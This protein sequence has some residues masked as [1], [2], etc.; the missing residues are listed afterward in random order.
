MG[1]NRVG[2]DRT[3][4]N[5]VTVVFPCDLPIWDSLKYTYQRLKHVNN[6]NELLTVLHKIYTL[7]TSCAHKCLTPTEVDNLTCQGRQHPFAGL[8]EFLI[9]V[10]SQ[11]EQHVFFT[12][13]LPFIAVLAEEIENRVPVEGLQ[14]SVRQK[15][16]H[17]SLDRKLIA[18]ILASAFLC[19]FPEKERKGR[20]L[21]KI[22]FTS[23]FVHIQSAPRRSSQSAKLRCILHYFTRLSE[24]SADSPY[25]YVSFIREVKKKETLPCLSDW[26]NCGTVMCSLSIHKNGVIEDSGCHTLQV[27]FANIQI[28][29][30]TLGHGRVQEEIRFCICPEL[31]ASM[32]FM[33]QM[34]ENE[35]IMMSGFEQFSQYSGYAS[36]LQ[37]AGDYRDNAKWENGRLETMI[38]SIDAVSYK[39]K[40]QAQYKDVNILRDLNKAL[41]GFT[42]PESFKTKSVIGQ[43]LEDG[44]EF[45]SC[46]QSA[47]SVDSDF[48]TAP[49]SL[50]EDDTVSVVSFSNSLSKAI[51]DVGIKDAVQLFRTE[52][53][54]WQGGSN[55][56]NEDDD[57]SDLDSDRG[58][59]EQFRRS[60]SDQVQRYG[61]RKGSSE[62]SSELEEYMENRGRLGS[63][64][65]ELRYIRCSIT[66]DDIP[67]A[68]IHIKEFAGNIA[69]QVTKAGYQQ[70]ASMTPGIQKFDAPEPLHVLTKPI[71]RKIT[72]ERQTKKIVEESEQQLDQTEE[73]D[74]IIVEYVNKLYEN[75]FQDAV[76]TDDI[77][78]A[79]ID[80]YA[81][82]EAKSILTNTLRELYVKSELD[83]SSELKVDKGVSEN[84][85]VTVPTVNSNT[86]PGDNATLLYYQ[87]LNAAHSI[88]DSMIQRVFQELSSEFKVFRKS[89]LSL[90]LEQPMQMMNSVTSTP[91]TPPPTPA[92]P[93]HVI[94]FNDDDDNDASYR[95]FSNEL[96]H[97]LEVL[98]TESKHRQ[99]HASRVSNFANNMAEG[100]VSEAIL[101]IHGRVN[102]SV[103]RRGSYHVSTR[104]SSKRSS[105]DSVIED[106]LKIG[107]IDLQGKRRSQTEENIAGFAEELANSMTS[108]GNEFPTNRKGSVTFKDSVLATFSEE[109]NKSTAVSQ[110]KRSSMSKRGS[111]SESITE[112]VSSVSSKITNIPSLANNLANEVISDTFVSL[113]GMPWTCR[114]IDNGTVTGNDDVTMVTENPPL[115]VQFADDM[116]KKLM[117]TVLGV[118][119]DLS[120]GDAVKYHDN[121][122]DDEDEVRQEKKVAAM[123]DTLT[124]DRL[125]GEWIDGI[126][127]CALVDIKNNTSVLQNGSCE[128]IPC[129]HDITSIKEDGIRLA[130]NDDMVGYPDLNGRR[131]IATGNWGCGAF[132]GD[133]QLKSLLQW[134][135]ASVASAPMVLYYTFNDERLHKFDEVS[136]HIR[137]R[138]WNV[139]QLASIILNF[140]LRKQR[141]ESCVGDLFDYILQL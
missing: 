15:G 109:L 39:R 101:K 60:S 64:E 6:I 17:A 4:D 85:D 10:A 115:A 110:N 20:N 95:R 21:N 76:A 61:S 99:F 121:D 45:F 106:L 9:D 41:V 112:S 11:E 132:G 135:A 89:S 94:K 140:S 87:E 90:S 100:I 47:S 137:S 86:M 56:N 74:P 33:E 37:F 97:S 77:K 141:D 68:L 124:L 14:Y 46:V 52:S 111:I 114:D 51:I 125:V 79:N 136:N 103:A 82:V 119:S 128:V 54:G 118:Q 122:E 28:G 18:S 1:K 42:L 70:A 24:S 55:N 123:E 25:G 71:A 67:A 31:I 117:I 107:D 22:N 32:L 104:S 5:A 66:E 69:E 26:L 59:I 2:R 8:A 108:C 83:H 93:N 113:F 48:E 49:E 30:G 88:A 3:S 129:N 96:S 58:W 91:S 139:G 130:T 138:K 7:V 27:N 34:D 131:P 78:I 50:D 102:K 57:I 62:V 29:G 38:S 116:S 98:D 81:S 65:E 35:A 120:N 126:L 63:V 43:S 84:D 105:F 134:M 13:T 23:F 44:D 92:D 127:D 40:P 12:K 19:T 80:D 75:T 53:S 73:S 36:T 16:S 72:P 133:V